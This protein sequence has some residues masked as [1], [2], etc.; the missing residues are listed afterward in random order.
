MK[1]LTI[2]TTCEKLVTL[3]ILN[4]LSD[5]SLREFARS[6]GAPI[7]KFKKDT[8]A[9]IDGKLAK[10]STPIKIVIG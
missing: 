8:A 4:L 9:S 10:K 6:I 5:R 2:T 1:K 3:S 7:G